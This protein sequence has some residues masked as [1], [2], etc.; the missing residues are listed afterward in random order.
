VKINIKIKNLDQSEALN[1]FVEKKFE[2]LAKLVDSGEKSAE[3]FVE[4]EKDSKHHKKGEIFLVKA[5]VILFGTSI[6]AE[7][8][9]ED[10]FVTVGKTRD[11]LKSEIEKFGDKRIDVSRREA[12]RSKEENAE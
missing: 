8:N 3:I 1:D 12:R 9:G 6:M 7:V 5:Q 10:L 2:S 4:I 11:E